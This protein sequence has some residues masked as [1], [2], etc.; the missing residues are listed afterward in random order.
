MEIGILLVIL[1]A[2]GFVLLQSNGSGKGFF[3]SPE[4]SP[5]ETSLEILKKRYARGEID[6]AEYEL[7]KRELI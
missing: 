6:T 5:A 4:A 3:S 2:T 7:R 1:V